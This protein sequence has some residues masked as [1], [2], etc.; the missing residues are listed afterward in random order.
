MIALNSIKYYT[1]VTYTAMKLF[2]AC[3]DVEHGFIVVVDVGEGCV[4]SR[5]EE[6]VLNW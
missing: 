3:K 1:A 6:G 2:A 5:C 4:S